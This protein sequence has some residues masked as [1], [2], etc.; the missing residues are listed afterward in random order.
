[1]TDINKGLQL[2]ST[3]KGDGTLELSLVE[4]ETPQPKAD[5]VARER[6]SNGIFRR[7]RCAPN[8]I[9]AAIR[10]YEEQVTGVQRQF[11]S[12]SGFEWAILQILKGNLT[13][14]N[15]GNT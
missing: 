3:V 9:K 11:G 12:N 10:A 7:Y 14:R 5:E 1:M 15:I 4:E 6:H 8:D 2:R 13:A